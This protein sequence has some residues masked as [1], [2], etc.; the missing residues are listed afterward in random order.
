MR[1][2][3][4]TFRALGALPIVGA[5]LLALALPAAAN[6][7]PAKDD[8]K[9]QEVTLFTAVAKP[10]DKEDFPKK[11]VPYKKSLS[12]VAKAF[13]LAKSEQKTLEDGKTTSITLPEKLGVAKITWSK[14]T[15][16]VKVMKGDKTIHTVRVSKFPAYLVDAKLKVG[17]QQVV[18]I[19][20]KGKR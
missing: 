19:L 4:S 3:N 15:A 5:L 18:L 12:R 6:D 1:T 13:R 14:K 17:G 2:N 8:G 7:L 9:K 11:L 20:D 16:T 10:G